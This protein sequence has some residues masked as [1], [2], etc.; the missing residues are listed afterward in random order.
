MSRATQHPKKRLR[1]V[2][3]ENGLSIAVI[4]FF[5]ACMLGQSIAGHGH[6]NEGRRTH[7]ESS[8]TYAGYLRSGHFLEATMENWE[9][10]FLQM[11][12]FL[13][14][15]AF[16]YQRG[17]AESKK[18]DGS[19]PSGRDPRQSMGKASAQW[20]VRRGGLALKLYAH[21][22][23]LAFLLL[24]LFSFAMHAV[25]GARAYNEEQL[26][27]GGEAVTT[28]EYAGTSQFWFESM[29]NWQSEFL[30]LAAMVILSIFLRER[31]SPQSKPVDAPHSATG[32]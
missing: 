11:F 9:S 31:G 26:A 19:E 24:F 20:P 5:L 6:Y 18:L 16:L 1:R 15:T 30:A 4:A 29:Q 28:V 2:L 23:S 27:H 32:E 3:R 17:S 12:A 13:L 8:V 14:F 25:G 7:G 10:E 22:L 21:S